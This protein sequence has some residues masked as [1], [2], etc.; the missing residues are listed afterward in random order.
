M[1]FGIVLIIIGI[2]ISG[3]IVYKSVQVQPKE[4]R[5]SVIPDE[6]RYQIETCQFHL[7]F[8]EML[9]LPRTKIKETP[10]GVCV[11][12]ATLPAKELGVFDRLRIVHF[13][14]SDQNRACWKITLV[15][16]S[17]VSSDFSNF[18]KMIAWK[19]GTSGLSQG[20]LQDWEIDQINNGEEWKGRA[21]LSKH[22]AMKIAFD[23]SIK[24][25]E[26]CIGN[27]IY[28]TS[29]K[30]YPYFEKYDRDQFEQDRYSI[31]GMKHRRIPKYVLEN[32][33]YGYMILEPKNKYDPYAIAVYDMDNQKI[34]YIPQD[35]NMELYD[36]MIDEPKKKVE[37]IGHVWEEC[38]YDGYI[39]WKGELIIRGYCSMIE[40]II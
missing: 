6:L 14:E 28:E 18:V 1:F 20:E 23:K 12:S 38:E 29:L 3:F 13:P 2:L 7:S 16:N 37:V 17:P 19:H 10:G 35:E 24:E 22:F 40:R 32:F 27:P 4:K 21:W 8:A 25:I 9:D 34:G 5:E 31:V 36:I 33:L 26:L 39:N 15:G 11:Y 30:N